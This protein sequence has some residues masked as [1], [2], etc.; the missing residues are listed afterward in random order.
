MLQYVAG[1]K[2]F[3]VLRLLENQIFGERVGAVSHMEAGQRHRHLLERLRIWHHHR[4]GTK[5]RS[6]AWLVVEPERAEAAELVL[7]ERR[8]R[9]RIARSHV[10]HVLGEDGA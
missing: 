2:I 9:A 3:L 6:G 4:G 10:P 7:R 1:L 5:S 8:P